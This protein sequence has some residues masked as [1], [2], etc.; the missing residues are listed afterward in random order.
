M[1]T[2]KPE[3]H[4]AT[5]PHADAHGSPASIDDLTAY[6]QGDYVLMRDARVSVM[7]HAFMYGT[8]VFEGIRAYWNEE[9]GVLYG[10][11][12]REHV[13]RLRRNA[14][15]LLMTGLPPV[16]GEDRELVRRLAAEGPPEEEVG[17][18]PYGEPGFDAALTDPT[19]RLPPPGA[20]RGPVDLGLP[21]MPSPRVPPV[22][23]VPAPSGRGA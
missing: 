23:P 1:L 4:T 22:P 6:F 17:L 18:T 3:A 20:S 9:Q 11:K 5:D 16:D 19:Y 8:A 14:G 13:E 21:A 7:T 2:E 10:L 15:M 12:L